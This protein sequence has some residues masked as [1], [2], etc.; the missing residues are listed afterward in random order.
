MYKAIFTKQAVKDFEKL[1]A[2]CLLPKAKA[3]VRNLA[4]NPYQNS[5]PYEIGYKNTA[6]F[7]PA[8]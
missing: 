5:P 2:A 4:Q 8:A 6:G 3:L 1:K 7:V